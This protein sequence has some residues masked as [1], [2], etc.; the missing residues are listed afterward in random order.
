MK[1]AK[2]RRCQIT[3]GMPTLVDNNS[4]FDTPEVLRGVNSGAI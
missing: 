2:Q 3:P 1:R 4:T